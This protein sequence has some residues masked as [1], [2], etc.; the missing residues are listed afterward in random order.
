MVE[1]GSIIRARV[2]RLE[3]YGIF[4]EHAE[5]PVCVLLPDVSW[6]AQGDLQ[7][8]IRVGAEYDVLVLRYNYRDRIVVGS[9]KRLHPEENPYRQLSRLEP[10]TALPAK[11]RHSAGS[12][13]TVELENGAW[14]HAPR[15]L[16]PAGLKAG[17]LIEVVI[18]GLE[19]DE[20]RLW[21]EPAQ[22]AASERN[23]PTITP[24]TVAKV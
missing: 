17:D 12:E 24:P 5:G 2:T 9:I 22:R 7:E 13:V 3:P 11:V 20:G 15:H 18:T 4:L 19:V 14:G 21:L 1:I 16:L 10:G 23:G 8:R 6:S